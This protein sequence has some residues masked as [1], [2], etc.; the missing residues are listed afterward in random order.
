MNLGNSQVSQL[1]LG[2]SGQLGLTFCH[3]E[4]SRMACFPNRVEVDFINPEK[5]VDLV[6]QCRPKVIINT[7]AFTQVELAE[8]EP[9]LAYQI[10]TH[11][12]EA[13]ASVAKKVG[14]L[15]VH[16]STDYVFDGS[17]NKAWC[18]DD[19][20]APLNVYGLSKWQGE[21]A[22]LASG[23]RYLI[24]RTSWLHSPHRS[25]FLKTMLRLGQ[26]RDSLFVISDQVGA[27][28]SAA[29]LAAVT[30]P[31]IAM[32]LNNPMLDGT[33]HVAAAGNVSRYNYADFIFK[34]AYDM[35]ML[36]KVPK[37]IPIA[38]CDYASSALRPLNSRLDTSHFNQNFGLSLPSW[39]NGVRDTLQLLTIEQ[40]NERY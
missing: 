5:L 30:F 1:F 15:L 34:E 28:T 33:Y 11:A 26:K 27:P 7:A 3:L 18:E 37:I 36:D 20:P 14:A 10:N 38:S 4:N 40:L 22:I 16:F 29:M 23:C 39:Q 25:N 17:G 24:L 2:G 12:V 13:L 31:A 21:Q 19:T 6:I 35:G 9:A 32:A 8:T